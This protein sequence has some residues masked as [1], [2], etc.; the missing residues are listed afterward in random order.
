RASGGRTPRL[1]DAREEAPRHVPS[2]DERRRES[3]APD[4]AAAMTKYEEA[5]TKFEEAWTWGG[6]DCTN[7][8]QPII[9]LGMICD[10]RELRG[11]KGTCT[12]VISTTME[13]VGI[14]IGREPLKEVSEGFAVETGELLIKNLECC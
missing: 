8:N 3:R 12:S 2:D 14:Q 9:D 13:N 6:G 10:E 11:G 5:M 7:S 1:H 4:P